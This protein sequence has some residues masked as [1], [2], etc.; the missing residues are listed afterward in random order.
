MK[1]DM[2]IILAVAMLLGACA[3]PIATVP[4]AKEQVRLSARMVNLSSAVDSYFSDLAEAPID[5]DIAILQNA[6]RNDPQLL[7]QEFNAYVLKVQFQNP[8]AVLLL[9][10]KDGKR[11]IMEDAG[12]SASLD[13]QVTDA[14]PC[15]FTLHVRQNC[16]VE[17]AGPQ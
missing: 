6:T 16:Q 3:V 11:A 4:D 10:S 8:Y 7:A 15:E 13:R 14:V 12:C 2:S 5:S 9:C 17:G 1:H